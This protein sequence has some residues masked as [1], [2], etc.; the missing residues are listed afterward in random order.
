MRRPSIHPP[1]ERIAFS[2]RGGL[3]GIEPPTEL[4]LKLLAAAAQ[5][6]SLRGGGWRSRALPGWTSAST[7]R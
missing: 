7:A 2:L 1:D 3:R 4:R 6:S 5:E